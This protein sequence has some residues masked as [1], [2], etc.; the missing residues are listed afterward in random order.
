LKK[1]KRLQG[2]LETVRFGVVAKCG[3]STTSLG[4]PGIH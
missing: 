4:L 1:Y 2:D 3:S